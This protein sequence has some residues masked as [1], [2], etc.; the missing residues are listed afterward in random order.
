MWRTHNT[1]T[2]KGLVSLRY[3]PRNYFVA[4]TLLKHLSGY[5]PQQR[6]KIAERLKNQ[7]I[8]SITFRTLRHFKATM[9]SHRTKD[10][11]HVMQYLGHKKVE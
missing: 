11:L 2:I 9:E 3:V 5:F 7:M 4:H 6:V 1:I 8:L 10:N